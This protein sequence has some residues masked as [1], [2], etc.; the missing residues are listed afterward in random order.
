M[1]LQRRK[2]YTQ[3]WEGTQVVVGVNKLHPFFRVLHGSLLD[4]ERGGLAKDAVDLIL[5]AL[6]RE[7][8]R[9]KNQDT[10][11]RAAQGLEEIAH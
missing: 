7:E 8:L 1:A 3:Q 5:I 4:L 6:V 2:L 11:E 9:T 10:N